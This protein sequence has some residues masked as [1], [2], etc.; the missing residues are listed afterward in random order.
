MRRLTTLTLVAT[1]LAVPATAQ[2][3]GELATDLHQYVD[4][5]DLQEVSAEGRARLRMIVDHPTASHVAKLVAIHDVLQDHDALLHV[6]MH[7]TRDVLQS[8]LHD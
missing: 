1:L 2:V 7:G 6:D 4:A 8:Q 5:F 3:R